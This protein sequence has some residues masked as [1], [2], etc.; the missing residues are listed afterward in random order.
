MGFLDALPEPLTE[1]ALPVMQGLVN[2]A[3]GFKV[4]FDG[5]RVLQARAAAQPPVVTHPETGE[6]LWFCNVHSHSTVLR[7]RRAEQFGEEQFVS[8]ASRI[9]KSDMFFGDGGALSAEEL[10]HVDEVTRR[11]IQFV[12]MEKG[13]V[14]LL[15]NYMVM[16]GR[17]V[18]S[19]TR[20]HAVTWMEN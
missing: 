20:K 9:N 15:D 6:P 11:N 5:Q 4:D 16:H 7:S 1:A 14:V 13:D 12:K 17:N 2:L 8:G 18:F 19:G 3:L 10:Q